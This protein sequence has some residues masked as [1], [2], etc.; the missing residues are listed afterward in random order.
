[1]KGKAGAI[2][3]AEESLDSIQGKLI[4]LLTKTWAAHVKGNL[5]FHRSIL[6]KIR[7]DSEGE[8]KY[9]MTASILD[10]GFADYH[11]RIA[12]ILHDRGDKEAVTHYEQALR[13]GSP[14]FELMNDY[15]CCLNDHD[16]TWDVKS[17]EQVMMFFYPESAEA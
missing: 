6:C 1:M 3:S 4:P 11:Y 16:L 13:L 2:D 12:Q 8:L 7:N 10:P 15:G 5:A 14:S 9:L 17:W